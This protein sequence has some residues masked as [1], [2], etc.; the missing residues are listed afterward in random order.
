LSISIF[1]FVAIDSCDD[2]GLMN[3]G[4]YKDKAKSKNS[5][6]SSI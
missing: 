6:R 1:E 3:T 2:S 4:I 5:R